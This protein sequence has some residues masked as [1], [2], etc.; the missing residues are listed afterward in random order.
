MRIFAHI[1]PSIMSITTLK[2]RVERL[3]E[4]SQQ[5]RD[6]D[7]L[8]VIEIWK[9]DLSNKGLLA[10]WL[11]FFGVA[12]LLLDGTLTKADTITRARRIAQEVNPHLRGALWSDRHGIAEDVKEEINVIKGKSGPASY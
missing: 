12:A 10:E 3:L 5:L 1:K 8:L 4:K 6:D 11:D 9:E 7:T 2:S